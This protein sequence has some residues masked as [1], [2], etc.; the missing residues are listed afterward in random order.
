MK[1]EYAG[2]T[3]VGMKRDHNEDNLMLL[4]DANLFVVADGMG[5]HSSGEVASQIAVD[6][7]K[8]F[9]Q[10]T[11]GD[12]EITWPYKPDRDCIHD[13]NRIVAGVKL[14]NRTIFETALESPKYK[15]MGTTFVGAV[16][17]ESKTVIA[18]AGDSRAYRIRD[19]AIVQLTEDHSLLN[20]YK[21]IQ[22][23]TP[24]E[25]DAF[26]HKNIIVRALGMKES[27]DVEITYDDPKIGDVLLLCSD[28]LCGEITDPDMLRLVLE[29]EDDLEASVQSLIQAACDHGGKDNVTVVLVKM[30]AA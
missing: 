21:K 23:M 15:G 1:L 10:E 11:G 22:P 29:H 13:A 2:A 16:Y 19:G 8:S 7:V 14:A 20:D 26:P 4:P 12:D 28:G 18:H 9:F 5:G 6:T 27:L 3:H 17:A 24:E 30:L 25:E